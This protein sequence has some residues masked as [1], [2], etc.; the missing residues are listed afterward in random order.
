MLPR[1]PGALDPLPDPLNLKFTLLG[2]LLLQELSTTILSRLIPLA[3][4]AFMIASLLQELELYLDF[5]L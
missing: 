5:P 1:G 4:N 3:T 2:L